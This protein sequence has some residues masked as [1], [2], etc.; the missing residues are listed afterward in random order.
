MLSEKKDPEYVVCSFCK[1]W[2]A[3]P[4]WDVACDQCGECEWIPADENGEPLKGEV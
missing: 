2:T 4:G 3:F 1:F